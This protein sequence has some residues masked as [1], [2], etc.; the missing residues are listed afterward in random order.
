MRVDRCQVFGGPT[1][2]LGFEALV[3]NIDPDAGILL[4]SDDDGH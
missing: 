2:H 3:F 4:W 1:W